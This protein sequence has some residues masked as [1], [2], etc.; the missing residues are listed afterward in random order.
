LGCANAA[1]IIVISIRPGCKSAECV[2]KAVAIPDLPVARLDHV[3]QYDSHPIANLLPAMEEKQLAELTES[4]RR[5]GLVNDIILLQGMVLD[6]RGRQQA[7]IR[8]GV[9]PRYTEFAGS[10]DDAR[11]FVIIQNVHRRHLSDEQRTMIAA[12]MVNTKLGSNQHSRDGDVEH[13][14]VGRASTMLNVK[15]RTVNR[16]LPI[17]RD[18]KDVA[19]AVVRG[20]ITFKT[21]KKIVELPEDEQLQ[22]LSSI[23]GP[24]ALDREATQRRKLYL[25]SQPVVMP[26]GR[27]NIIVADFPWPIKP[28]PAYPTM[29]LDEIRNYAADILAAKAADHCFLFL[30]ATEATREFARQM[31]KH[32]GWTIREQFTWHKSKGRCYPG[33]PSQNVEYVILAEKGKPE[34]IDTVGLKLCFSG[35]VGRHSEKPIE[36]YEMVKRATVGRRLELFARK[37]HDGFEPHGNEVDW[38]EQTDSPSLVPEPIRV[39]P[40]W[41]SGTIRLRNDEIDYPSYSAFLEQFLRLHNQTTSNID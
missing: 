3:A 18:A 32:L 28:E 12:L 25:L 40:F 29:T 30:W 8:A 1:V 13:V 7:C 16:Y 6:G 21:A 5:K 2:M 36:F 26:D 24:E 33:R 31:A 27:F 38:S 14:P 19:D 9:S 11:A 23:G 20:R 17:A 41:N 39:N 37:P 22:V 4:I 35:A 15:V 10:R 34:F